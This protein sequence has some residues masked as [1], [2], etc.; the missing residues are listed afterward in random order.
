MNTVLGPQTAAAFKRNKTYFVG[1]V[2]T[3]PS[4]KS[5]KPN[6]RPASV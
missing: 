2:G 1:S 3:A 5:K 4:R 6:N